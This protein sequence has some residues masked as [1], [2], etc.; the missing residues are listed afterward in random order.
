MRT[1]LAVV[2]RAEDLV[3]WL[4][5]LLPPLR[6]IGTTFVR[7]ALWSVANVVLWAL[8]S[9]LGG[10][11]S[12]LKHAVSDAVRGGEERFRPRMKLE[13]YSSLS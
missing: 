4:A 6:R 3:R 7:L 10:G 5:A 2:G 1:C 12:G 11:T 8:Q 9:S 13:H